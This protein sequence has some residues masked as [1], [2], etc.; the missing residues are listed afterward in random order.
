M[1]ERTITADQVTCPV[2]YALSQDWDGDI[3]VIEIEMC[4]KCGCIYQTE[5]TRICKSTEL[6][7]GAE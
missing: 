2:C 7:K 5:F 6:P 1:T 3:G 4:D